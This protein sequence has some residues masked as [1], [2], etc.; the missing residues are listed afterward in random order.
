MLRQTRAESAKEYASAAL[1]RVA[2]LARAHTLLSQTRWEG[3]WMRQLIGEELT[4]HSGRGETRV[5]TAGPD[6]AL[7]PRTAQSFAMALH[8]LATNAAK[9]GALSVP[10][11][12]VEFVWSRDDSGGLTLRWSEAGGPK[13][14][15]PHRRGL[16]MNVLEQSIRQQL[17]GRVDCDWRPE[18]LVC[19]LY[20]PAESLIRTP[21]APAQLL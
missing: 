6:L 4:P 21:R 14:S 9:H 16:G 3:A 11:G 10:Q 13:V 20:I 2:A 19:S 1:G 15:E 12:R 5:R 17:A 8:E 18:G 7:P